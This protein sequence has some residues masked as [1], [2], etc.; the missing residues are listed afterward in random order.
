MIDLERGPAYRMRT[1]SV[2]KIEQAMM[3]GLRLKYMYVDRIP[4]LASWVLLAGNVLHE[5]TEHALRQVA[6]TGTYPD[7]KELDDMF[8]PVWERRVSEEQAKREF[9]GWEHD[10]EDPCEKIKSE[11]R[12]LVRLAREQV[13][14][15]MRPWTLGGDPV[16]E[17][18]VE[19]EMESDAGPFTL[20]G[21][22]DLLADSGVLMD[23]KTTEESVSRRQL[24]TWLQFAGYSIWA[25][26]IVGK[27]DLP[28][29]KIF[30][31]RGKEPFV[32]RKPF[33]MT[34]HHRAWFVKAAAQVW[35]SIVTGVFVPNTNGWWCSSK[36]CPYWMGCQGEIPGELE[37]EAAA[38]KEAEA[39]KAM[40]AANAGR[41]VA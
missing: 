14:S 39:A 24:R 18:R 4:R 33:V 22:V 13:L 28:C 19:I 5:I 34:H 23:W 8:E 3:C 26:P 31:V 21:Y 25:Y 30:L 12:P 11:Y 37:A 2:S 9:L 7:W 32:Q 38:R 27:E 6:K 20:L 15:T 1:L 29:E 10:P 40:E 36:F 16:V 17:H 35:K 41:E